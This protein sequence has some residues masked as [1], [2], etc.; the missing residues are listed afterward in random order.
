[1]PKDS[2]NE[3]TAT[4]NVYQWRQLRCRL[5]QLIP[6]LNCLNI[7]TFVLGLTF[8]SDHVIMSYQIK[9]RKCEMPRFKFKHGDRQ[10]DEQEKLESPNKMAIIVSFEITQPSC[11]IC[12]SMYFISY[13]YSDHFDCLNCDFGFDGTLSDLNYQYKDS[14]L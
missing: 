13:G 6:F 1:L 4:G 10:F 7:T 9:Q 11:P 12:G 2:D 5:Y 3:G 14:A 8:Y